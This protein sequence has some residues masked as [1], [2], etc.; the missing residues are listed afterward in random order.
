MDVASS[1]VYVTDDNAGATKTC[2]QHCEEFLAFTSAME[3]VMWETARFQKWLEGALGTSQ[4]AELCKTSSITDN[5]HPQYHPVRVSKVQK[6]C[7]HE[8]KN[9][10]FREKKI[11]GELFK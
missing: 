6:L 10:S 8:G 9:R 1:S 7:I 4:G 5:V 11:R 2:R 3:G